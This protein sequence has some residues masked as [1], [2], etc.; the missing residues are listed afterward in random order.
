MDASKNNSAAAFGSEVRSELPQDAIVFTS[1]NKDTFTLWYYHYGLGLRPDI[2][3]INSGMLSYDW[4]RSQ[5]QKI[6]PDLKLSDQGDCFPCI[7]EELMEGNY[8]PICTTHL[9]S[10]DPFSCK[11]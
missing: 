5:I 10:S 11:P 1:E 2:V 6:Y 9:D 3:V 8:R 4:Y 7:L